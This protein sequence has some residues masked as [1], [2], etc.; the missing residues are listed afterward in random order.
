MALPLMQIRAVDSRSG[1]AN[2]N[3]AFAG[4][5]YLGFIDPKHFGS[6]KSR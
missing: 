6:A 3:F 5:G 1:Y 2:E 4:P